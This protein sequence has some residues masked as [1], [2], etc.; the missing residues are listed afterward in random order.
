MVKPKSKSPTLAQLSAL[1][2]SRILVRIHRAAIDEGHVTGR[3]VGCSRKLL[4][5]ASIGETHPNGFKVFR[6]AD[7]SRLDAPDRYAEFL[8]AA[9]RLRGEALT[10]LPRFDLASWRSL[11]AGVARRFPL[12]TLHTELTDPDVCHI[13]R[14]AR[15]TS[16]AATLVTIGPDAVWDEIDPV[17]L[18]WADVT[19]V[20]FGGPYEEALALVAGSMA[21]KT[22]RR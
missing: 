19:E 12:V 1:Q 4:A 13:G 11:V 3:I 7:V 20:D 17:T 16:R 22:G 8:E 14:P 9:L 21:A 2:R 18:P 10:R 6:R 15:L 5:L